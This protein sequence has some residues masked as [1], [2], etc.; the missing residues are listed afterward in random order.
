MSA[1]PQY[2]LTSQ[3]ATLGEVKYVQEF[4][5]RLSQT[6]QG[7]DML[8]FFVCSVWTY[9]AY[10]GYTLL[11]RAQTRP[12]N[13]QFV[14]FRNTVNICLTYFFFYLLGFAVTINS[15][16]GY[17]GSGKLMDGDLDQDDSVKWMQLFGLC[18]FSVQI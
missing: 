2:P 5:T 1:H 13:V 8:L 10:V 6:Q 15:Q 17:L 3:N 11:E 18:L 16:G 14:L 9:I 12:H 7:V 4:D